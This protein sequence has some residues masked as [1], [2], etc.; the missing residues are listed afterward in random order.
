MG[1][2]FMI[3]ARN[4]EAMAHAGGLSAKASA[5][6]FG[7]DWNSYFGILMQSIGVGGVLIFGFVVSWVFGREYS[8]GTAKDLLSLPASRAKIIHAKFV[9]YTLWCLALALCN[10]LLGLML[11]RLLDLD[12]MESAIQYHQLKDYGLTALM[13][14]GLGGPIAYFAIR[15]KGYMAPL[16]FVALTLVGAQVIAA[17]GYGNYFPWSMPGLYSGAGGDSRSQLTVL[18]YAI[19][20]FTAVAGYSATV[21][22]WKKAD[23]TK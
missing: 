22:Y 21:F 7:A 13:T 10:F 14:I 5:L 11:A 19:L 15:G 23:Q 4:P 1:G 9:V 20:I 6:N 12:G 8:D 3:I 17:A 18:S 2:L 16:G